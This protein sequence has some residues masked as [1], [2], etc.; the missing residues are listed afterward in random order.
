MQEPTA[1]TVLG[2]FGGATFSHRGVVSRFFKRGDTFYVTTDGA[3]G[4]LADFPIEYVFGVTPLQQYLV[5]FPGG[6]LQRF[7]FLGQSAQGSGR[8]TLVPAF[9]REKIVHKDPL[10]WTGLCR[11]W[12]L[13]CAESHST[14]LRKGY[15]AATD[16]YHTNW[17]E[18]NVSPRLAMARIAPCESA[19]TAGKPYRADDDKGLAFPTASRW[20]EARRFPKPGA[21]YARRDR[22]TDPAVTTPSPRAMRAAAPS[23]SATSPARRWPTPTAWRC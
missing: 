13:R 19:K 21:R 2:D 15:D 11:N 1:A 14:G 9:C 10:H 16:S 20:R 6:R 4:K 22:P 8:T 18:L 23:P 3:D 17:R 12:N 5:E 7:R